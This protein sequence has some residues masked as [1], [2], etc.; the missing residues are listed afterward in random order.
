MSRSTPASHRS[1]A[2]RLL[3]IAGLLTAGLLALIVL[4]VAVAWLLPDAPL[5]PAAHA[6]L[7]EPPPPPDQDNG[8]VLLE[9]LRAPAGSD[10][11]TFGRN[12]LA[13]ERARF[14][15]GTARPDHTADLPADALPL[16]DTGTLCDPL[17]QP[18]V[19]RWLGDADRVSGL[20]KA[21]EELLARLDAVMA[22]PRFETQQINHPDAPVTAFGPLASLLRLRLADATLALE[23]GDE[24]SAL[25]RLT[26]QSRFL[27]RLLTA[28]DATLIQSMVAASLLRSHLLVLG[29]WQHR[30]PDSLKDR[31]DID[32]LLAAVDVDVSLRGPLRREAAWITATLDRMRA[33]DAAGRAA[34]RSPLETVLLPAF[35]KPGTTLNDWTAHVDAQTVALTAPPGQ[36]LGALHAEQAR[37]LA[38]PADPYALSRLLYN[39]IG[40]MLL[41]VS[42]VDFSDYQLRLYD[43]RAVAHMVALQRTLLQT[44]EG[45]DEARVTALLQS[46]PL[47]A[48][49]D[50]GSRRIGHDAQTHALTWQPLGQTGPAQTPETGSY[51]VRLP[52]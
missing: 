52:Y 35:Y 29:E 41:A 13:A 28:P 14:S 49:P 11:A 12:R 16:P 10:Y 47:A 24:A 32:A 18:C 2:R 44:G 19:E 51:R 40:R 27:Q 48:S 36:R 4:L 5:S 6:L 23:N 34:G 39:P 15:A 21:H 26:L 45:G 7:A 17:R 50:G 46:S 1:L 42:S 38:G 33:G 3:R 22:L 8:A 20:V 9:G 31:A 25:A 37:F 30:W 43:T